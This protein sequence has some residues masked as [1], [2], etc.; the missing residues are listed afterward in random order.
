VKLRTLALVFI[1]FLG[2]VDTLYL[3]IKRG[4]PV[5][6]A[7]TTGCEEV[8][9][10]PYSAVAGVPISWF[11]FAFYLSVFSAGAFALFGNESLL[12]L[13]FWPAL[14]AFVISVGLV[15]IQAFVLRAYCQYC[16]ASAVLVTL[17]FICTPKPT[18]PLQGGEPPKA[19]GGQS[20]KLR[21]AE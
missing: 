8:L 14:A 7:I 13:L 1:A 18:L 17:I 11:G 4:K 19:A 3:G 5:P 16:L 12:K 10:S 21:P 2:L 20:T 6:C 15:G 9:N